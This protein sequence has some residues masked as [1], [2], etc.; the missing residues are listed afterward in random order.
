MTKAKELAVMA[1]AEAIIQAAGAQAHDQCKAYGHMIM[2]VLCDTAIED[3]N[4]PS[5]EVRC[6]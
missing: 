4:E 5:W 6:D 1:F 2:D 3:R